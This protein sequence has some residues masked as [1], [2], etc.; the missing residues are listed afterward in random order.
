MIKRNLLVAGIIVSMCLG[1][2]ACGNTSNTVEDTNNV[3]TESQE[4]VTEDTSND[5]SESLEDEKTDT[6]VDEETNTEGE[7]V[8]PGEDVIVIP[9]NDTLSKVL[10][11]V[12]TALNTN[13]FPNMEIMA[14]MYQTTYGLNFEDIEAI[15]GEMPMISANVDTFIGILA[16]E[17]SVNNVKA[18]LEKYV[19]TMKN[20][21]FQY[22]QN[23]AKM[24]AMEVV[25]YDNYVFLVATFGDVFVENENPTDEEI[26]EIAK[27][28]VA[29]A[30]EAIE[31]CFK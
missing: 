8:G 27:A 25:T 4:N 23:I 13:Y 16:K 3:N 12:R 22:P 2:A 24:P 9:S 14:E 6:T 29:I 5:N 19:E 10:N 7:N 11:E 21:S 26:L 31:K 30:K 18:A 15:Y 20:D 1:M 17:G 28:N